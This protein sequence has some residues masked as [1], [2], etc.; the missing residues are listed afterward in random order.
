MCLC[1]I[2]KSYLIDLIFVSSTSFLYTCSALP[3]LGTSDHSGLQLVVKVMCS[4]RRRGKRQILWNY[5]QGDYLKARHMIESTDWDSIFSDDA[6][7]ALQKWQSHFLYI[8]EQCIPKVPHSSDR[9][10]WLTKSLTRLIKK[11]NSLFKAWKKEGN[12]AVYNNYKHVR[13]TVT[14]LLRSAKKNFFSNLNTMDQKFFLEN[15][16]SI[17]KQFIVYSCACSGQ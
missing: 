6:S 12:R 9:L 14:K 7:I 1:L 4:D 13:N 15:C 3:P 8:M 2:N 5:N 17:N 11:K 10:L 16:P